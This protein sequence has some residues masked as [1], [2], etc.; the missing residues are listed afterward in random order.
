MCPIQSL[1]LILFPPGPSV[2]VWLF[3]INT[4]RAVVE[5]VSGARPLPFPTAPVTYKIDNANAGLLTEREP[6]QI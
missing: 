3:Q 5:A 6:R 1:A 4:V 2:A